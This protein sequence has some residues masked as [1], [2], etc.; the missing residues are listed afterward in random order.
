MA[1]TAA[2][3]G[4]ATAPP[5]APRLVADIAPGPVGSDPARPF[6]FAGGLL[7]VADDGTH[8]R[9]LWRSDG[10]A[11]GTALVADINPGG[12]GSAPNGFTQLGAR[13]FF[14]ADD[15]SHGIEPWLTDGTAAGTHLVRDVRPG[16]EPSAAS[17]AWD[18]PPAVLGDDVFFAATDGVH[19][20]ELW[21]SDGTETGTSLV[22]D[23]RPGADD[24]DVGGIAAFQSYL[25]F[26][27]RPEPLP[28]GGETVPMWR[29]DGTAAGTVRFAD[30]A[31]AYDEFLVVGGSAFFNAWDRDGEGL[32]RLDSPQSQPLRVESQAPNT[33]IDAG[34]TLLG[35]RDGGELWRY[36]YGRVFGAANLPVAAF[37]RRTVMLE[38]PGF[39]DQTLW[40]SGGSEDTTVPLQRLTPPKDD[41]DFAC[42]TPYFTRAGDLVY[43]AA[44]SG[45]VGCELWALPVDALAE[46]CVDDCPP[47]PTATPNPD[48]QTPSPA[49]ACAAE[50]PATCTQLVVGEV[51]GTRGETVP[52]EVRLTALLTPIAGVQ[53]D[54]GFGRD[55]TVAATGDGRPACAVNPAI[56][57]WATAFA[58]QP[59]GCRPGRDCTAV[60]AL[61]LALDNVD[62]IADGS[63]LYTCQLAIDRRATTGRHQLAIVNIGA[64]DP[65][66]TPV[67][68]IGV[69]GG[70]TVLGSGVAR[71]GATGA[72]GCQVAAPAAGA[73]G[74]IGGLVAL[75]A[76]AAS[77]A[78]K[79]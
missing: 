6:P 35:V 34:G 10:T 60:R 61:V 70:V 58:F 55:A 49:P 33:L 67:G 57:K 41:Y 73:W 23:L 59:T 5:P 37:G 64:S 15:G 4:A 71:A 69:D 25:F 9:E 28:G 56:D 44:S 13:A 14:F 50:D 8:G 11:A 31:S 65:H 3:C 78:R 1:S 52:V 45:D 46:V 77:R 12:A 76:C 24:A 19:G 47:P 63:L 26:N 72:A 43:F 75:L 48:S 62:P 53:G 27:T 66:G 32:W 18:L 17:Y 74:V 68:M 51:S 39:P 21:R 40:T 20:I 22:V 16:A 2:S 7:F 36:G 30:L 42:D 29:S 79:R 38:D 54:L